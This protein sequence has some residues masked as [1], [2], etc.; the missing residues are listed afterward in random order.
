MRGRGWLVIGF[1]LWVQK[2]VLEVVQRV[3]DGSEGE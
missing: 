3:C 1:G 2:E